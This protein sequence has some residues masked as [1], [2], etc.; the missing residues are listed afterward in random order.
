MRE[1]LKVVI[2]RIMDMYYLVQKEGVLALE[3]FIA[4]EPEFY[5]KFFVTKA[6]KYICDG[7]RPEKTYTLLNNRIHMEKDF[8]RHWHKWI[9]MNGLISIQRGE[10]VFL[11]KET[12][13]SLVPEE[14]EEMTEA[15]IEA[16]IAKENKR[17]VEEKKGRL[18]EEFKKARIVVP[19]SIIS[20][21]EKFTFHMLLTKSAEE[22]QEWLRKMEVS[23]VCSLLLVANEDF[24]EMLLSGMSSRLKLL[25]MEDAVERARS[26]NFGDAY[27]SELKAIKDALKLGRMYAG[28]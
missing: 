10:N 28:C 23:D 20:E 14:M 24:R 7:I 1:D 17:K 13:L 11:L 12:L 3:E 8:E 5:E 9:Y 27:E 22:V 18:S 16:L 19:N 26:F 6:V 21:V 2:K 4:Q 25:I 15:Y